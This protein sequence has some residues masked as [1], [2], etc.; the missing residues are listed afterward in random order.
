[1]AER[2]ARIVAHRGPVRL[3]TIPAA[4]LAGTT[5]GSAA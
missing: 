3:S 4:A 5:F 1:M 2:Y